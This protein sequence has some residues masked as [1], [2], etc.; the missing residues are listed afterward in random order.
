[1]FRPTEA[2]SRI[3]RQDASGYKQGS[4]FPNSKTERFA[5]EK[6]REATA[7]PFKLKILYGATT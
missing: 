7:Q 6:K 1:M 5:F 3:D 2:K 4:D